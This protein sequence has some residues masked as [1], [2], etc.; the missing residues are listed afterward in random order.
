MTQSRIRDFGMENCVLKLVVPTANDAE[1]QTNII[2]PTVTVN[3]WRLEV[4]EMLSLVNGQAFQPQ[5]QLMGSANISYGANVSFPFK[6][7]S[8]D[9]ETFEFSTTDGQISL[10]AETYELIGMFIINLKV[11][12]LLTSFKVLT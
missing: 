1:P 3:V 5:R 9:I 12:H 10:S 2:P 8:G 6:C 11:Y 4:K 7:H